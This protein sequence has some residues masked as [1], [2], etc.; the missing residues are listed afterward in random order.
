MH[1]GEEAAGGGNVV[2]GPVTNL[3]SVN[4]AH[5]GISIAAP[6]TLAVPVPQQWPPAARNFENQVTSL[7]SLSSPNPPGPVLNLIV[8]SPG[9]GKS[10]LALHWGNLVTDRFP[11]GRIYLDLRGHDPERAIDPHEAL[12][13]L[14]ASLGVDPALVPSDTDQRAAFWRSRSFSRRLLVLLDNAA[15]SDQVAPL[16]STG[17]ETVT[18]V[19]S[20]NALSELVLLA[21]T[22]TTA[23]DL[24]A[25]DYATALLRRMIEPRRGP[26]DERDLA[27]LARRCGYLQLAL[28]VAVQRLLKSPLLTVAELV[29]ELQ[30][31][32]RILGPVRAVFDG[33]YRS[34]RPATARLFRLLGAAPGSDLST[35]AITALADADSATVRAQIEE[36]W[37]GHLLAPGR[38]GRYVVHDLLQAYAAEI[39]ASELYQEESDA[40]LDRLGQ[41]YARTVGTA[42]QALG[43]EQG[44]APATGA[45]RVPG[46]S[47]GAEAQ[48]WYAVEEANLSV[49]VGA[50]TARGLDHTAAELCFALVEVHQFLNAASWVDTA[51]TGLELATRSDDTLLRAWFLESWG[52]ALAQTGLQDE[53]LRKHESALALRQEAGD[54]PAEARSLNAIGLVHLRARRWEQAEAF[55]TECLRLAE[56]HQDGDFQTFALMNLGHVTL[57]QAETAEQSGSP[58]DFGRG[59]ALLDTAL[60]RLQAEQQ[61][62]YRVNA[63]YDRAD[64][65]LGLGR[66]DEARD[67]AAEAAALARRSGTPLV[68]ASALRSLA[69]VKLALGDHAGADTDLTES[70]ELFRVLGD[71]VREAEVRAQREALTQ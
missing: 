49:L 20:R 2:H 62:F 37:S 23:V 5:G 35:G 34:L 65:L 42:A 21:G 6:D 17:P 25:P 56:E 9:T 41:W 44:F 26:V 1:G 29:E 70:L 8:G 53:A 33:S 51:R 66:P 19:T 24:L 3:I 18:V 45:A 46:F 39:A 4:A 36:L 54:A 31:R 38:P 55:F 32:A 60:G 68:L 47:S 58:A 7:E 14:L 10:A 52:K 27:E 61:P 69:L 40:G 13:Y 30:G 59:L 71:T 11:D 48:R 43:S 16:L 12:G 28:R 22:R 63:L 64:A 15:D 67:C 57:R 50:L